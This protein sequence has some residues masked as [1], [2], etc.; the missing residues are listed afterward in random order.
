M[1]CDF[2]NQEMKKI[3]DNA[4]RCEKCEITT[5]TVTFPETCPHYQKK[6]ELE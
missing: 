5:E 1:K 4:W 6:C 3:N 2:C